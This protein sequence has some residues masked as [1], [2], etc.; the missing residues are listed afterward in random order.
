MGL[1]YTRFLS[2]ALFQ[3]NSG[4][5]GTHI[6]RRLLRDLGYYRGSIIQIRVCYNP[7]SNPNLIIEAGSPEGPSNYPNLRYQHPYSEWLFEL[8]TYLGRASNPAWVKVGRL[9]GCCCAQRAQY[10]LI[11]EYSLNH[12]MKP[13]II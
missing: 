10:P 6:I 3:P 8:E 9:L 11:K 5:K 2:S 12:N 7:P 4:K 13:Y 1:G